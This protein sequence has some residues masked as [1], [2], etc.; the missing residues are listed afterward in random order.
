MHSVGVEEEW[1]IN[2][3]FMFYYGMA[4]L[5]VFLEFMIHDWQ[6]VS[7]NQATWVLD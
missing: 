6:N 3:I 7:S 2:K 4:D 1:T 5:W